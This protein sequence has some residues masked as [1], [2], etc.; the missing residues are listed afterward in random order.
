MKN[1]SNAIIVK[2]VFTQSGALKLH[3]SRKHSNESDKKYF[4]CHTCGKYLSSFVSLQI[5]TGEKPYECKT[6]GWKFTQ[7]G[8]LKVHA[9][10]HLGLK[11]YQCKICSKCFPQEWSLKKHSLIHTNEKPYEC[12]NC[13]K[14]FSVKSNLK[15]HIFRMHTKK[16]SKDDKIKNKANWRY[17]CKT[18]GKTFEKSFWRETI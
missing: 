10:T 3:E 8:A 6:C 7:S 18:C 11:P 9:N 4:K 2:N 5:H 14:R 15:V 16:K 17:D 13:A 1:L 12:E